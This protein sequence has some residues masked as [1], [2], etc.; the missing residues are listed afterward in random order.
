MNIRVRIPVHCVHSVIMYYNTGFSFLVNFFALVPVHFLH[1][2]IMH[3]NAVFSCLP[4]FVT[5]VLSEHM[6]SGVTSSTFLLTQ[7]L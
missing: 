1:C 2:V 3:Y 4:V 7:L 6:H 5:A